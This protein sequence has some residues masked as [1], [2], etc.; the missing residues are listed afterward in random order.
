MDLPALHDATLRAI[1]LRWAEGT[2]QVDVICFRNGVRRHGRIVGR[3]VSSMEC[4]RAFP[5]GE[6]QTINEI[7]IGMT[8]ERTNLRIE[9]QSGDQIV[10]Q[11]DGFDFEE[12]E[13]M[14]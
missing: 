10:L 7:E 2:V 11:A 9:M 12:G 8:E 13:A 6:S 14:T 4:P 1:H 5:W 3:N